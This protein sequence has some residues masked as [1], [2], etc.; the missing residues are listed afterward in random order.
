MTMNVLNGPCISQANN[1]W[2]RGCG[3]IVSVHILPDAQQLYASH[4]SQEIPYITKTI[5]PRLA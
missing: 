5:T 4:D 3:V 2:I 1:A